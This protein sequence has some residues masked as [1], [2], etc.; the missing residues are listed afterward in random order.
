MW[1]IDDLVDLCDDAG[2]G[3][4]NGIILAPQTIRGDVGS[5]TRTPN[6]FRDLPPRPS[7][8][9]PACMLHCSAPRRTATFLQ[10]VQRY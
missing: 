4:L 9:R 7:G 2:S 6:R 10:F 1:W 3:A 5:P 8:L